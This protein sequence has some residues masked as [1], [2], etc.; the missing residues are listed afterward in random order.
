M[1]IKIHNID[2]IVLAV[3]L[4][5]LTVSC[6]MKAMTQKVLYN[7]ARNLHDHGKIEEAIEIYKKVLES[8]GDNSEVNYDLGVAYADNQ[9]IKNAKKQVDVLR[10]S[11]RRDLADVLMTVI[12]DAQSA[13]VRKKLQEDQD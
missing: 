8:S 7:R 1:K 9:D 12:S 4:S 5:L 2:F 13:R 6:D 10:N 3:A 11:D